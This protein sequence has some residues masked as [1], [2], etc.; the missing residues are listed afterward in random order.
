VTTQQCGKSKDVSFPVLNTEINRFLKN[1]I[2]T[3]I[4]P[5]DYFEGRERDQLINWFK[6]LVS[7]S[8]LESDELDTCF[9]RIVD[10][11]L[12][13]INLLNEIN[14]NKSLK[15]YIIDSLKRYHAL[16]DVR[17][18][19]A[20]LN[21]ESEP[22]GSSESKKEFI[23][24]FID[25]VETITS[26]VL[27]VTT[28]E[29]ISYESQ[30]YLSNFIKRNDLPVPL[31]YYIYDKFENKVHYK[32]NFNLLAEILCLTDDR[33]LLQFGSASAS[34][35]GKSSMLL[36]LFR[37][38]RKESLNIDDD[39]KLHSCCI[40][41][42]FAHDYDKHSYVIFDVHGTL[43]DNINRDLVNSIQHYASVQIIYVTELDLST[44][45]I[46]SAINGSTKPTIIAIFD[47]NYGKEIQAN[48]LVDEF[49]SRHCTKKCSNVHWITLPT[50]QTTKRKNQTFDTTQRADRLRRTFESVLQKLESDIKQQPKFRSCFSI[51]SCFQSQV[52]KVI[53]FEIENRLQKLF[54]SLTSETPDLLLMVTPV[55]HLQAK[56][57]HWKCYIKSD[58]KLPT[59][60][61]ND[62]I[63]ILEKQLDS[64]ESI[65]EYTKFFIDLLNKHSYIE[66]LITERYLEQ[67]RSIYEPSLKAKT[68][69]LKEKMSKYN[70]DI[71]RFEKLLFNNKQESNQESK[72]NQTN[73]LKL[74][75][76]EYSKLQQQLKDINN[77]LINID[78]T[79]G[80]FCDEI[81]ALYDFLQIKKSVIFDSY[82]ESF[83]KISHRMAQLMYKG[84]ALHIL[85]EC[86]Q[87]V[88]MTVIGEQSSAKSSLLNS[89]FGCNFRVSAG[90]CTIGMYLSIVLWKQLT[91]IILDTE[92]LL[93]LEEAG[94]IFDNQMVSMATLSSQLVLLNTK[95]EVSATLQHLLGMSFYAKL[96][97][98]SAVKPKLQFV[99]RD[100][101]GT[102]Q[103][104]RTNENDDTKCQNRTFVEQLAKLKE[105]L[106]TDSQFLKVSIDDE[107]E[108]KSNSIMLLTNAF[109]DDVNKDLNIKQTYRSQTFPTEIIELRKIIFEQL[110]D[111]VSKA[112]PVYTN[113]ENTFNKLATNWEA[114]DKLG[115]NLL[116]CKTLHELAI[117]NEVRHFAYDIIAKKIDTLHQQGCEQM[118]DILDNL[119]ET[120]ASCNPN[121]FALITE[122]YSNSLKVCGEKIASQAEYEFDMKTERSC[123]LPN[124][125]Q[126][127]KQH[128]EPQIRSH[129]KNYCVKVL[130]IVYI[131]YPK[132][133]STKAVHKR[134]ITK[135][136]EAF[137]QRMGDDV[138]AVKKE[139]DANYEELINELQGTLLSMREDKEKIIAKI[140][141]TYNMLLK[142][143]VASTKKDDIYNR[144]ESLEINDY[145]RGCDTLANVQKLM[146]ENESQN[147][148]SKTY[149]F[150]RTFPFVKRTTNQTVSTTVWDKLKH[151][152]RWF[153][154]NTTSENNK[155]IF[156][157]IISLVL[158]ALDRDIRQLIN[159]A[160]Y[161]YPTTT[162]LLALID[163]VNNAI[164]TD[165]I[166]KSYR[167]LNSH[168]F[169]NDCTLLGLKILID[170]AIR[171]EEQNYNKESQTSLDESDILSET[172]K[173]ISK[174]KY[175]NHEYIQEEAYTRSIRQ[176]NGENIL[177]YVFDINRYFIEIGLEL[178]LPTLKNIVLNQIK[179]INQLISV[180]IRKANRIVQSDACDQRIQIVNKHIQEGIS[181][182]DER[183]K[184][185]TLLDVLDV[186]IQDKQSF[187]SGFF[188]VLSFINS[189]QK[190]AT[191][192]TNY[193]KT[194]T[195]A[196]CKVAIQLQL[197]CREKCPGCNVK[198][199]VVG[200]HETV[201]VD[202]LPGECSCEKDD[203]QFKKSNQ[204]VTREVVKHESNYHIG[205]AFH[206]WH[207]RI[208]KNP[209]LKICY[210][211]W[212]N[213]TVYVDDQHSVLSPRFYNIVHPEWYQDL[214]Q[215]AETG[216][217]R[218]ETRMPEDQRR[219][220]M[221]VRQCL[222]NIYGMVDITYDEE[223]Y[224]P[225][226]DAL[227]VDYTPTWHDT[228][229]DWGQV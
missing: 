210:Q 43:V 64:I 98:G 75:K 32:I 73:E 88:L 127:V 166:R 19:L 53:Y 182:V 147:S 86:Q 145:Q 61:I 71:K 65:S 156:S 178:T 107:L 90:R 56:I 18:V 209:S 198:C 215:K 26:N 5:A 37:D 52:P 92:G 135:A 54:G 45:F 211:V 222:I 70:G 216:P 9:S 170:E 96:Q 112:E 159:E 115:P 229:I 99:L 51:Q 217:Y 200:T 139:L 161:S 177:K 46:P 120:M 219:A 173:D 213:S 133:A 136:Q 132:N 171:I 204:T 50:F 27:L 108:I 208:S 22:D 117:M 42:L 141:Y 207:Q 158:P 185:F 192:L 223:F 206:S 116:D 39:E 30:R 69:T 144:L 221:T 84:F 74:L 224:P 227:P 175:I 103:H 125:K 79:I 137:N 66:L 180:M 129:K 35:R 57:E 124:I 149:S 72:Q 163:Y 2:Y 134:L 130:R 131:N 160:K 165:V 157:D 95:G 143:K 67:W 59:R 122:R 105:N 220:W 162:M 114:I 179:E 94:S 38:K 68:Y 164:K 33:V 91:I 155:Q 187:K 226:V 205:K 151:D 110:S 228:E 146:T 23:Q 8:T 119:S 214:T 181:K 109:N 29:S 11:P 55:S 113:I 195:L 194:K 152:L 93:S 111:S 201:I 168:K 123:Y 28:I 13:D 138:N 7:S 44:D 78:L 212:T 87:P 203:C 196:D 1:S 89:T 190:E 6:F 186:K 17:N 10:E 176:A 106:Y 21:V 97:I 14:Q 225:N 49:R 104:N 77:K 218:K 31:S 121:T 142:S 193:F 154:N 48:K 41:T 16:N 63:K 197:G 169:T 20:C 47:S 62:K 199:S 183:L 126:K 140:L 174:S 4:V 118:K 24:G 100:Q 40:D 189:L 153:P 202:Y 58:W 82:K 34:G 81:L 3:A 184:K 191:D 80:L 83:E 167:K 148:E 101:A 150:S 25:T 15:A 60:E 128:I 172:Q 12:T 188:T 85:R 36:Y 76:V 102:Q